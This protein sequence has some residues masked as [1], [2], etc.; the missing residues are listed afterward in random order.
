MALRAGDFVVAGVLWICTFL[1]QFIAMTLF[2]P[3]M[4]LHM[5]AD[6]ATNLNGA[7]RA[8][9]YYKIAVW[10]IPLCGYSCGALWL[11]VRAYKRQ[12]TTAAA[13]PG[14]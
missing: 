4:A 6:Q 7:E 1:L 5:F 9:R 12:A 3:D 13:P 11:I 8:D 14:F 10:Y 2:S